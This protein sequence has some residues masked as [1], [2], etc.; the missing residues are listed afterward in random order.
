MLKPIFKRLAVLL[1]A[2]VACFGFAACTTTTTHT[3]D[4]SSKRAS[5]NGGA[6]KALAELY[7]QVPG[8]RELV[9]RA[10]GVLVFPNVVAAGF[11][12]GA[13]YGEGVLL[14]GDKASA[15]YNTAGGSIGLI[16]GAQSKAVYVLFLTADAL[17]KFEAS[18]GWTAGADA[19]VAVLNVG[20]NAAI[21]SKT[22]QQ[23]I[24]GFVLTNGGL[25]ANATFNGNKF[26]KLDL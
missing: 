4:N 16:A 6:E 26:T 12:V 18:K 15:Y 23:P 21:D 24:V 25:M 20:A 3:D 5:I 14:K 10:N 13:S 19:S 8:S 7:K 17:S 2:A 22:V 1:V 11:G 9:A